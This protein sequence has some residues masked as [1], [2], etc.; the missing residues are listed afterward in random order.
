MTNNT[1]LAAI[2]AIA[3]STAIP[4]FSESQQR[5]ALQ[6]IADFREL[7]PRFLDSAE[8]LIKSGEPGEGLFMT[9]TNGARCHTMIFTVCKALWALEQI[10]NVK[11]WGENAVRMGKENTNV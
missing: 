8:A 2:A 11:R 4:A 3:D 5:D 10:E 9:A 7:A 1:D 6:A